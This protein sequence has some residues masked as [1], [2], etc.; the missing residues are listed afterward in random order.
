[1]KNFISVFTLLFSMLAVPVTSAE[2]WTLTPDASFYIDATVSHPAK[3]DLIHMTVDCSLSEA[4]TKSQIRSIQK[5]YEETLRLAAGE[6]GQVRRGSPA[7][8]YPNFTYDMSGAKVD[9]KEM[10]FSGNVSFSVRL[11]DG[12]RSQALSDAAQEMGCTYG[13]D[14]RIGYA[15]S[16]AREH[17]AEL[18]KQINDKKEF[19]ESLF[20]V[21]FTD[22]SSVSVSSYVDSIYT[23]IGTGG[24]YDPESNTVNVTTTMSVTFMAPKQKK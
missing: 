5:K 3:P 24:S 2:D 20:N 18:M 13:W 15:G 10:L 1:M 4:M 6:S 16:Y 12:S 7:S 21:K 14:P 11:T 17:R 23:G 22:V 9:A 19:Y 8:L